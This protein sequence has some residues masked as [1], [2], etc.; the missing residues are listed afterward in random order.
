MTEYEKSVAKWLRTYYAASLQ[1]CVGKEVSRV[2]FEDFL[3]MPL[4]P[5]SPSVLLPDGSGDDCDNRPISRQMYA[6]MWDPR[7]AQFRGDTLFSPKGGWGVK[8]KGE[9]YP[10]NAWEWISTEKAGEMNKHYKDYWDKSD[11]ASLEWFDERFTKPPTF[12]DG[13]TTNHKYDAWKQYHCLANLMPLPKELN[14]W[15][16]K[17]DTISEYPQHDWADRVD[18]FLEWVY[19]GY[20]GQA[21]KECGKGFQRV[22]EDYREIYFSVF[23]A[24]EEGYAA[25]LEKNFLPDLR[26]IGKYKQSVDKTSLL[27]TMNAFLIYRAK[28]MAYVLRTLLKGT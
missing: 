24:D 5:N 17:S 12:S 2:T 8:R 25:F 13:S 14:W 23:G 11:E 7:I 16:G 28:K 20:L 15:R 10:F 18:R 3:K 6:L 26:D 9:N 19:Y 21:D 4:R 22:F 1:T 27:D